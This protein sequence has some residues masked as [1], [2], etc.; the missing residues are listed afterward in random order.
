[1]ERMAGT[2]LQ[3]S[4]YCKKD[5]DYDERGTLPPPK[6]PSTHK[7]EDVKAWA[8][9]VHAEHGRPPNRRELANEFPGHW[10]RYNK[11]LEEYVKLVCPQP[12]LEDGDLRDW[13]AALQLTV[14]G[15]A[16]DRSIVF[17]VDELGGKGKTWF[18]RY[19]ISSFPDDVQI[20]SSGKRDDIAHALDPSKTIFLFNVPRGGM[21]FLQYTVLEQIK[22][23]MVFSPK[24]NSQTK[25]LKPSHVVVFCNEMPNQMAMT[26][27]RYVINVME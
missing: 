23:R 14:A 5:G 25:I 18:Q 27:D 4:N 13:Q 15:D 6:E 19:M 7:F 21:E 8:L 16:D 24:Y 12:V 2:P 22:D 26:E 9:E 10:V 1:M 17:Q 11:S 20:L 3:A